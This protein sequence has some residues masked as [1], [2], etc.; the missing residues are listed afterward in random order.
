YSSDYIIKF[1]SIVNVGRDVIIA[2]E[3]ANY[4]S[5]ESLLRRHRLLGEE[6]A[7]YYIEQILKGV[8]II[9]SANLLHRDIKPENILL[10]LNKGYNQKPIVKISDFGLAKLLERD[11]MA[12]TQCGTPLY[13]APEVY[14]E[15][16][17]FN[18]KAD[19]WSIGIIFYR[20]LSGQLPYPAKSHQELMRLLHSPPKSLSG[21]ITPPCL[22]LLYQLMDLDPNKRITSD[23]A[24]NHPYFLIP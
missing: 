14:I 8:N 2:M 12:S 17:L 20:C 10:H 4:K 18:L 7:S 5:L 22:E 9:H 11:E 1:Y 13:M 3:Y 6:D 15:N 23:E 21:L 19:I 24:L 16:K